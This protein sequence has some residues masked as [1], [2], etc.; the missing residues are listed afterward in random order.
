MCFISTRSDL[1]A[2][3]VAGEL[4]I[5]YWV[6][7]HTPKR[8]IGDCTLF[9]PSG[10]MISSR[11]YSEGSCCSSWLAGPC[12]VTGLSLDRLFAGVLSYCWTE[13][14]LDWFLGLSLFIARYFVRVIWDVF[15]ESLHC[16]NQMINCSPYIF[17]QRSISAP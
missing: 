10:E 6:I 4:V 11:W 2:K 14:S 3:I 7:L 1:L 12:L 9:F 8:N 5:I 13:P 15:S 17:D 16:R